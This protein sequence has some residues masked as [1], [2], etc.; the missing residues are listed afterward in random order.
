MI[1][2]VAEL[3]SNPAPGWK[4]KPYVM[5]AKYAGADVVKLQLFR[6]EHFPEDEQSE[7][8]VVQ[9]PRPEDKY[10]DPDQLARFARGCG[11]LK[12]RSMVSVFDCNAVEWM[13]EA[14]VDYCKL[15]AREEG[16][17]DLYYRVM[18]ECLGG[19]HRHI[20]VFAS[21]QSWDRAAGLRNLGFFPMRT[22]S[23]YPTPMGLALRTLLHKPRDLRKWGWSS[24]TRG[25]LDCWLAMRLGATTI[26]KHLALRAG[27]I[28]AGHSLLPEEFLWMTQK[29]R[30]GG[31]AK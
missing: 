23:Q 25:W 9:F 3:G 30:R 12:I 19:H 26:E 11:D 4:L 29:L 1:Q 16:N 7:K 15:A 27:E 28:E 6:A 13:R 31:A 14:G 21:T 2:I 24:H 10:K 22:I 18:A 5:A 17:T 8:R 20:S